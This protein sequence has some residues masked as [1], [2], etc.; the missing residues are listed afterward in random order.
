[1]Y[2]GLY[3]MYAD[4]RTPGATVTRDHLHCDWDGSSDDQAALIEKVT[5]IG[6]SAV[7]SGTDGHAQIL[8]PLAEPVNGTQ[9]RALCEALH[10]WLPPGSDTK[11]ATN[12]VFRLPGTWSHKNRAQGGVSTPVEW[13]IRPT[14]ARI[15]IDTLAEIVG[16]HG[17]GAASPV[18]HANTASISTFEGRLQLST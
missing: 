5:K 11:K 1:M 4:K 14:S 16:L 2:I 3:L 17:Q 15:D 9:H 13:L 8:V 7:A 6:G 10:K 12:D 18:F